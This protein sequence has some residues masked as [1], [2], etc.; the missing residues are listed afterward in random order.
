[1]PSL[2]ER[3]LQFLERA[4]SSFLGV[5]LAM[6][7]NRA[8]GQPILYLLFAI[9]TMGT[10]IGVCMS[11]D[12]MSYLANQGPRLIVLLALWVCALFVLLG[13]LAFD[14]VV[15]PGHRIPPEHM[16][17]LAVCLCGW[18]VTAD[19]QKR[20]EPFEDSV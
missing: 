19:F 2:T 7:L 10:V 1:M 3:N 14:A 12:L 11:L 15:F 6:M 16:A 13:L 8:G 9:A 18:T 20:K 5:W 17:L 4:I